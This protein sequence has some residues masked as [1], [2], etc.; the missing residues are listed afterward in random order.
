MLTLAVSKGRLLKQTLPL[1]EAIGCAPLENP[2]DSRSLILPTQN[3]EVRL[4]VV[5]A[6]DAPTYVACGAAAAGIVGG[7]I[8]AENPSENI[9]QPI[10]LAIGKC[11]LVL[12]Q[13]K[14]APAANPQQ[15]IIVATKYVNLARRYFGEQNMHPR[16]IKLYGSL[17]LAPL[18]GMADAI[19]DLAESG[20]TLRANGLAETATI[21]EFSA[22][23]IT[24]RV[25]ARRQPLLGELQNR[26]RAA[27]GNG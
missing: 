14:D 15:R 13:K 27:A 8:T 25:A 20:D 2:D 18:V 5:R 23:F 10:T 24:N 26:L 3:P 22:V 16:I 21:R 7:D 11:R 19:I 12:A 1:L 6:Q 9:Y 17:E 4:L